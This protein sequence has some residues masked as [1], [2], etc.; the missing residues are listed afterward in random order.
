MFADV[1]VTTGGCWLS[2][3]SGMEWWNGLLE[4]TGTRSLCLHENL[5]HYMDQVDRYCITN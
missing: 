3:I 1:A 5:K 2:G 4:L